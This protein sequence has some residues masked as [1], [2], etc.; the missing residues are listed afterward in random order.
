MFEQHENTRHCAS[1]IILTLCLKLLHL[2][3]SHGSYLALF[4]WHWSW[5]WFA[6]TE[7]ILYGIFFTTCTVF[8]SASDFWH[9]T[10]VTPPFLTAVTCICFQSDK[11]RI[12]SSFLVFSLRC[13]FRSHHYRNGC[14][15]LAIKYAWAI[16]CIQDHTSLLGPLWASTAWERHG[17]ECATTNLTLSSVHKNSAQIE[18]HKL[19]LKCHR[20]S[21]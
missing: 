1:I 6:H 17:L 18:V 4:L 10:K 9:I 3:G 13:G 16:Y 14:C 12:D 19:Y 20:V 5:R 7:Q 11:G 2:F 8:I 15:E 21:Y